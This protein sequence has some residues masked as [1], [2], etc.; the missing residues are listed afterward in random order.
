MDSE[1]NC[2]NLA[3]LEDEEE[4]KNIHV[5]EDLENVGESEVDATDLENNISNMLIPIVEGDKETVD[6]DSIR[7]HSMEIIINCRDGSEGIGKMARPE[8]SD[9]DVNPNKRTQVYADRQQK[10]EGS[11]SSPNPLVVRGSSA[12]Q[13]GEYKD[14]ESGDL[15]EISESR[16]PSSNQ[17]PLVEFELQ[18]AQEALEEDFFHISILLR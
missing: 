8:L 13:F 15:K 10:S 1:N 3:S 5:L 12:G 17:D 16:G 7:S 2:S 18:K 11:V 4:T 14:N 9:S 6:S